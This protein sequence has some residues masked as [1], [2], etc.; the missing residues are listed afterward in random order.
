MLQREL[1]PKQIH[2]D[3]II[4]LAVHHDDIAE[5]ADQLEAEPLIDA[6]RLSIVSVDFHFDAVEAAKKEAVFADETGRLGAVALAPML[7]LTNSDKQSAGH[8]TRDIEQAA[9]ADQLAGWEQQ[10]G[11]F[12]TVGPHARVLVIEFLAH[13]ERVRLAWAAHARG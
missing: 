5:P 8:C 3:L 11:E 7:A 9:E 2:D 13:L 6:D 1:M 12:D 4:S 10:H